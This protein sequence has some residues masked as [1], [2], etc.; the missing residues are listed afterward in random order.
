[1]AG[2]TGV[3]GASG[4]G[5]ATGIAGRGGASGAA[6]ATGTGG[7]A[8]AG[9]V[10]FSDDFEAPKPPNQ[11][12]LSGDKEPDY[13]TWS[14]VTNGTKVYQGVASGSD[15]TA[16]VN[17]SVAWTDMSIEADVRVTAGTSY[18]VG[19]YGRFTSHDSYYIMYMDEEGRLK[20]RRRLNGSTMD[21][22]PTSNPPSVPA[23]N[24][25]HRFR[26]DIRGPSVTAY[27]DGV[28]RI[29]AADTMLTSGGFGVTVADSATAQFDN[30]VVRR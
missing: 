13:G 17:G 10:L 1:V 28:M 18:Q 5:G 14:V 30:V 4:R 29:S 23:P 11:Q 15:F 2:T 25:I 8:A 3:A 22:A 16:M 12:W 21:L 19:L 20:V 9:T 7:A 6:G 24:T 27:V 26:L